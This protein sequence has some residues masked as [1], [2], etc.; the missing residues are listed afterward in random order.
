M[1]KGLFKA[2]IFI[3]LL[4]LSSC[5]NNTDTNNSINTST[6]TDTSILSITSEDVISSNGDNISSIH[7]HKPS[8]IIIEN[9]IEAT[10]LDEGSYD[11]VIYCLDCQEELSREHKVIEALGHN[12]SDWQIIK[13][14]SDT[15]DG[16]KERECTRCHDKQEGIIENTSP[17][18]FKLNKDKVSYTID[19][20]NV[21]KNTYQPY[22]TKG[23]YNESF[24]KGVSKIE[25]PETFNNLP[26]TNIELSFTLLKDEAIPALYIGKNIKINGLIFHKYDEYQSDNVLF[27][28]LKN[29]E[30]VFDL[31]YK[32][33]IN[34]WIINTPL[35]ASSD[36]LE[37][38]QLIN[39]HLLNEDY[40]T[41][42][43]INKLFLPEGLT[44]IKSYSFACV[45]FNELVCPNTLK[46]IA[47]AS[48]M[49]NK[50]LE[51]VSLNEGLTSVSFLAFDKCPNLK[52]IVLPSSIIS[53]DVG[54]FTS[55]IE[56]NVK[57]GAKGYTN[58]LK[59][60]PHLIKIIDE[61]DD[62]SYIDEND[63]ITK[64][65]I[66]NSDIFTYLNFNV[67]KINTKYKLISYTSTG[68]EN[69][70]LI[71][72]ETI[73][74]KEQIINEYSV[75]K[76]FM[77][78]LVPTGVS[79]DEI[80][81]TYKDIK[82]MR[83]YY[84]DPQD[85]FFSLYLSNKITQIDARAFVNVYF[86]QNIYFDG[87]YEEWQKLIKRSDSDTVYNFMTARTKLVHVKNENN[88]YVTKPIY[89]D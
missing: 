4:S 51:K 19:G 57:K 80:I 47:S 73:M 52:S 83:L 78:Q 30:V 38:T 44:K 75:N 21:D 42:E 50:K 70:A 26:I 28:S 60:L 34:D 79:Y 14:A 43:L 65:N 15:Q 61:N 72:P 81:K 16:L 49:A 1:K 62:T 25:I 36:L 77:N 85:L 24:T 27:D 71:L 54:A 22:N 10:C 2:I 55:L 23:L 46:D 64:N 74:Y 33:D 67:A 8:E 45:Q 29:N 76:Y 9:K 39:L 40:K 86:L 32:G 88:E 17:F 82:Q 11:E 53:I 12:Y 87:S 58:A 13:E 59:A 56:V 3:L 20:F 37:N 48:F 69:E 18:T 41:Y 5:N 66:D 63:F 68:N 6:S 84:F 7:T 35:T 31:F 89:A